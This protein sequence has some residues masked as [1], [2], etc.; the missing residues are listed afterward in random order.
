MAAM[1][2]ATCPA[3]CRALHA[4]RTAAAVAFGVLLS[5]PA[6]AVVDPT[7]DPAEPYF[8]GAPPA[9]SVRLDF[10]VAHDGRPAREIGSR[11]PGEIIR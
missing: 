4:T 7:P 2:T 11:Q 8:R 3:A 5:G 10:R 1:R 6:L 9:A